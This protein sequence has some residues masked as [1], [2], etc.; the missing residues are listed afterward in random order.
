MSRPIKFRKWDKDLKRMHVCGEDVHDS[1]A[2]GEN[3]EAYYYNEAW[4]CNLDKD[5]ACELMQYTGLK[6]RN[7]KEIYEGDV[8]PPDYALKQNEVAIICYDSNQARFKAVPLSL[9]KANAGNGGWTGFEV[10][11]HCSIIGNIYETPLEDT[12]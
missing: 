4:Y 11:R 10:T 12:P 1:I 2:F 9:Y 8:I 7:G 5:K 6:D 3:N